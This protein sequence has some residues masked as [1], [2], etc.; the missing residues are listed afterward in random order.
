MKPNQ[1]I[2]GIGP[3][4]GEED[5]VVVEDPE[6]LLAPV[7]GKAMVKAA[8]QEHQE[9]PDDVDAGRHY[10]DPIAGSAGFVDKE[11]AADEG[12]HGAQSMAY[13]VPQFLA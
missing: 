11:T 5:E 6:H 4:D 13:G 12:E 3:H 7:F 10:A 1:A 8:H 2:W 9:D